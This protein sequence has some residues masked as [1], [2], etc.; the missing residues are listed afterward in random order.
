MEKIKTKI[1][2]FFYVLRH[3]YFNTSNVIFF[4]AVAVCAFW[5]YGSIMSMTR[6]WLLS[7]EVAEKK[8]Q[9]AVLELEIENLE[10]ENDY[11]RSNEYKELAARAKEGKKLAG[12]NLVILPDNSEYAKGKYNQN[13]VTEKPS[14]SNISH[15]I[16]FLF[17]V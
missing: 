13:T 12:E 5:T 10:L 9:L 14:Y 8:H 11:Y 6:N 17:G 2:Q 4:I 16:S 7:E 15:W 1:R 3:D